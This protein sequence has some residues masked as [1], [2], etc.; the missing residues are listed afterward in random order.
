[1]CVG[2]QRGINDDNYV[3]MMEPGLH[4]EMEVKQNGYESKSES[5]HIYEARTSEFFLLVSDAADATVRLLM[6]GWEVCW[7]I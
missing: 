4:L 2:G 7:E 6:W 1:M 5:T 3:G